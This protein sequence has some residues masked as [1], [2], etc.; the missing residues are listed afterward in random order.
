MKKIDFLLLYVHNTAMISIPNPT[1]TFRR[2]INRRRTSNR[3]ETTSVDMSA[4]NQ[5]SSSDDDV[6]IPR[7][8]ERVRE[9]MFV[10]SNADYSDDSD[11]IDGDKCGRG[12]RLT[13]SEEYVRI[14]EIG[15]E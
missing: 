3:S 8:R 14:Y 7:D 5:D 12:Y 11:E 15:S 2:A 1:R 6:S 4:I 10:G 13:S 9:D